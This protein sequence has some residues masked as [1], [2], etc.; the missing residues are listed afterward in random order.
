[1]ASY[2]YRKIA[3]LYPAIFRNAA[4]DY[5]IVKFSLLCS[6]LRNKNYIN[7]TYRSNIIKVSIKT[8]DKSQP[9][10]PVICGINMINKVSI[11]QHGSASGSLSF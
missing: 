4:P 3:L 9:S 2:N 7:A 1:M 8:I 10:K 5:V 6:T 11:K